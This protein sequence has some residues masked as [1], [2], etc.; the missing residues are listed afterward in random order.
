MLRLALREVSAQKPR[1]AIARWFRGTIRPVP[2]AVLSL[3]QRKQRFS[4]STLHHCRV[5]ITPNLA[6]VSIANVTNG[7]SERER[8][9]AQAR[10]RAASSSGDIAR[11]TSSCVASIFTSGCNRAHWPDSFRMARRVA[12]LGQPAEARWRREGRRGRAA[13]WDAS[14]LKTFPRTVRHWFGGARGHRSTRYK[15]AT[16]FPRSCEAVGRLRSRS[17][18][19]HGGRRR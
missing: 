2:D 19:C 11:P 12:K 5:R 16:C 17:H 14:M 6:P 8:H 15:S 1:A 13:Y 9:F 10:S 18:S 7:T 3:P 4:K